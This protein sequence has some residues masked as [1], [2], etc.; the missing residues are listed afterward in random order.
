[1]KRILLCIAVLISALSP[2]ALT[3]S[4]PRSGDS[5]VPDP[6]G[7]TVPDPRTDGPDTIPRVLYVSGKV[8]VGDGTPP[9]DRVL[10]QSNCD[11][12]IRTEGYADPKGTFS[13]EFANTRNRALSDTS[14]AS[15]TPRDATSLRQNPP[16]DWRK[17]E[18]K[19]LLAGYSSPVVDLGTK[20]PAFGNFNIGTIVLR[21]VAF[22]ND[23]SVSTNTAQ[24]PPEAVKDYEKGLDEKKK[25]NLDAAQQRFRKAVATYPQFALA[26]LE[27]G[28]IQVQQKD[29]AG[30][31]TSFRQSITSDAKLMGP[32]QELAQLAARE[33]QWQ[34]VVDNTE[35][36]LR[37][38]STGYPEFWFY[39][40]VAKFH[41][42]DLAG[43]EKSA[44]Q[45]V[46][47]DVDRRIPKM[48]YVLGT[49]LLQKH[50]NSG[51]AEHFRDYLR[52]APN[53]PDAADTQEKLAEITKAQ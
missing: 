38:N 26:W 41:L 47:I 13:F 23:A 1:M 8:V 17:C 7:G 5:S 10:I 53:G 43:A 4:R 2:S 24:S 9:P 18:L 29:V 49:I 35:Q 48:E 32:Y 11:G 51:A 34:E 19:A 46:K 16:S 27:L 12:T 37:L 15:D 52:L 36:L 39:N 28:R 14:M 30:A 40:C 33:K 42:G 31:R 45:G 21:R 6:R 50:D 20:P 25:G 22:S 3:Q 44:V